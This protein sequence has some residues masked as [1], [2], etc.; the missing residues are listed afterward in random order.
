M[1]NKPLIYWVCK[2]ANESKNIDEVI[3]ST[4]SESI[5]DTVESFHFKKCKVIKRSKKTAT[6]NASTESAMLEYAKNYS[7]DNIVL[8]QATSPDSLRKKERR[9]K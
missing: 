4:D 8:I 1:C 2:A 9:F 6:D 3:I 5:K 7:F